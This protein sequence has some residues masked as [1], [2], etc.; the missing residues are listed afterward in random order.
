MLTLSLVIKW[1]IMLH[2]IGKHYLFKGKKSQS[3]RV[4]SILKKCEF[5]TEI[6]IY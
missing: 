1:E 3:V 6:S 4:E 5:V 2:E